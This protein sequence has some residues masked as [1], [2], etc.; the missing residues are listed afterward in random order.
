[1][2]DL[3]WLVGLLFT[4]VAGIIFG[5]GVKEQ[6]REALLAERASISWTNVPKKVLAFYYA[7]YGNPQV[8]G[9]WIHWQEV[10][11]A[12]KRIGSSTHYP[13]LG[14]Y[15]SH[16]PK[17]IE[18]HC[19]WAKEAGIDAFIISW[20]HPGDFHD[21]AMPLI[22]DIAQKFGLEVSAY[23]ET[24]PARMKERALEYVMYLLNRYGKHSAWLKLEGKPVIF[25]YGRAIGE[26][27]LDGWL[28]V[29]VEANRRYGGGAVFIGDQISKRAA[30]IFDG[31][32]TYNITGLTAGKSPEE[33]QAWAREVFPEWVAIAGERISCLTIIPGYDDS[34]LPDRKPPRPIT[35]RHNGETYRALWEAAIEA[36]P[37][38]ILITSWNEWHEGSEIE[39][40]V[41]HGD[42]ELKIT[43]EF[44]RKFKKLAPRR[45]AKEVELISEVE[46]MHLREKLE[47]V[48]IAILPNSNSEAVWWLMGMKAKVNWLNYEQVIDPQF[49]NPRNFPAVLYG[50]GEGYKATVK[51]QNDVLKSLQRYV[52]EGGVLVVMPSMPMPFHYDETSQPPTAVHHAPQL[53]L[54]LVVAWE[55]PPQ[56]R[57]LT[58]VVRDEKSLPHVPKRF[59]YPKS[60][61]LRWRPLMPE[62][63]L[64]ETKIHPLIELIDAEG[65]SHGLGAVVVQVDKGKVVYVWF[66]LLDLDIGEAIIHDLWNLILGS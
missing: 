40:S 58:F 21:R 35:E 6:M 66:R 63:A 16:D 5:Q 33:I 59:D 4:G 18:Q 7:W 3:R 27:G 14:P 42:R 52:R 45:K 54:P 64:P 48:P 55:Q 30:R 31:I 41:E 20:W 44:S 2:R 49:F 12:D 60:G 13:L 50:G 22:L 36:N 46:R 11:E 19:R 29:I 65:N 53:W 61:D 43:A 9:R 32:H 62:R 17:I 28:W 26:I 8:S 47:E 51:E 56:G 39:P 10:N 37:D 15:D 1:M 25:V 24:V 34:K 38:W 23:F 57:T